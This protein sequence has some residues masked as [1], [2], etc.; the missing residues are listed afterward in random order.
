VHELPI[1]QHILEIVEEQAKK[2]GRSRVKKITIAVGDLSS[3]EFECVR[4]YFDELKKGHVA[5]AAVLDYIK[6]PVKLKCRGCGHEFISESTLPPWDCPKCGNS[7]VTIIEG[8]DSFVESI[9]V[10]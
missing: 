10:E 1:T 5:E 3:I 6:I 7:G 2:A 8:K 9:E 4:F